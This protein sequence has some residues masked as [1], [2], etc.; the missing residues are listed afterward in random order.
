MRKA[1]LLTW[2][3]AFF[4]LFS[5]HSS[6]KVQA[7]LDPLFQISFIDVGQ[8]DAILLRDG[9]GF[10]VLVDGGRPSAGGL[11]L[12]TLRRAG[13]DD[14]EAL[15]AT[16]PDQDH[17]GGL[18]TVLEAT[19]I[20]VEAAYYNGYPGDTDRW[21]Q[22]TAAVAAEGL[23]LI[24]AQSSQTLTW[25]RMTAAVLNPAPGQSNPDPNEA[26]VVLRIELGEIEVLLTGDM[27]AGAEA[28]LLD[29]GVPLSAEVLK[30]A[31]H[32]SNSSSTAGFL[33]AVEP[34]T[35]VI[36]SGS[37]PYGHPHPDI[38]QRLSEA[39]ARAW[40]TD[41]LGTVVVTS[42]GTTYSI[43]PLPIYLPVIVTDELGEKSFLT[44]P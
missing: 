5:G 33:A 25:G 34:I 36:S 19:D 6:T 8:G 20:P 29:Q 1:A 37:N 4:L 27:E 31:H 39:G 17:I 7:Q 15:V 21:F 14:L 3:L 23:V 2:I 44:D 10:D 38:L 24:P 40:R 22:F 43:T 30:V 32:G 11:V 16:H 13:V 9:T 41:F 42:D 35:A 28:D 12:D 18:V 26:S